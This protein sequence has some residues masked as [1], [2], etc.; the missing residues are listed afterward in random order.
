MPDFAL[1]S[2][3]ISTTIVI[4]VD[5]CPQRVSWRGRR[6]RKRTCTR[7]VHTRQDTCV[8]FISNKNTFS[9]YLQKRG[10]LHW[11]YNN[12]YII[13]STIIINQFSVKFTWAL[14][15]KT[16]ITSQWI[17]VN[18]SISVGCWLTYDGLVETVPSTITQHF[19]WPSRPYIGEEIEVIIKIVT[20]GSGS[21]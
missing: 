1:P 11:L 14:F 19:Y 6:R 4:S 18:S 21:L 13:W 5:S 9:D 8:N 15:L 17:A 20:S 16:I 12:A 7:I 2:W 10:N 3:Y